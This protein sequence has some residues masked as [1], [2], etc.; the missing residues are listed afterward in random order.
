VPPKKKK[1]QKKAANTVR[2]VGTPFAA[3]ELP[4]RFPVTTTT[5]DPIFHPST[6]GDFNDFDCRR[7]PHTTQKSMYTYVAQSAR[8]AKRTERGRRRLF[9]QNTFHTSGGIAGCGLPKK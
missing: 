8:A 5:G 7:Q 3:R 2:F 9:V 4:V 1:T 6:A